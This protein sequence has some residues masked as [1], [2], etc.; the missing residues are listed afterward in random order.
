MKCHNYG[1]AYFLYS[2]LMQLQDTS[3]LPKATKQGLH[4]FFRFGIA[5]LFVVGIMA[6]ASLGL[7]ISGRHGVLLVFASMIGGYMAMN[8]G[9]NDVANNV[10]PAVGS[11]AITM[12]WAIIMAAFFEMAGAMIAGGDVVSTIRGGIISMDTIPDADHFIAI[13]TAA[14]LAGAL[15]LNFA[16]AVGAPVST[17]HA[18]V[19]AV[20]GAGVA[21]GGFSAANWEV[22]AKIAASWV[23]SP[24]LGGVIAAAFLLWIKYAITY[25]ADMVQAARRAVPVLIGVMAA[26]FAMYLVLKGL[27]KLWDIG[28]L[29]TLA[30]GGVTGVVVWRVM[31]VVVAQR[32]AQLQN[33]KKAINSLFNV[34]LICAAA[35]LSFAHG[36][37][38]VS[39]AVGPLAAIADAVLQ[40]GGGDVTVTPTWVMLVGALGIAL[41]LAL[42]GPKLIQ[43]VGGE[44]TDLDQ[45]RA[46]C[47]AMAAS[48]TVIVA[49]Q[50]GLPVSSTHIAI[51]GIFGVGFLRERLKSNYS[52][53]LEKIKEHHMGADKHI[54]EEYLDRFMAADVP[55]KKI[56]LQQLKAHEA[57]IELSRKEYKKIRKVYRG[58]LVKRTAVR[59]IAAAW[60]ITVPASSI[61]AAIIYVIIAAM[62]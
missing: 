45:M 34:P 17:T 40:G 31:R 55:T 49:A 51:G 29:T 2:L 36:A 16:T 48:L 26:V 12:F 10:G 39:N 13:M 61:M 6:Y 15:W 58:E 8:I 7:G 23:I 50:L 33:T 20:L 54:V 46:F 60:L 42:Y 41:G 35:L 22:M 52:N 38:D 57:S 32:A 24:V 3:E 62:L 18:V 11:K 28:F 1:I 44:I 43:T 4:G 5:V 30:F 56:M 25:K 47:V 53:M 37:S 27:G 9:A 14:L 19:G 21:A 59:K